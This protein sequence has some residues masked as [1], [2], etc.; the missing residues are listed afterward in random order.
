M[1]LEKND[2]LDITI[3]MPCL[4][5]EKTIGACIE[6]AQLF[7]QRCERTGEV[8]VV[9]NGSSDRSAEIAR[10]RHAR[11]I[12]EPRRGYGSAL[13]R[14]LAMAEGR[15]ILLGDCDQTYDF[16][17]MGDMLMALEQ[18]ADL[19]IG[20]R[21]VAADVKTVMPFSHY[22]GVKL[23][24]W[25]G[26]RRYHTNVPDYHCGLRGLKKDAYEKLTLTCSGMEFAT[27]MIAEAAHEK[28][29]IEVVSVRLKHCPAPRVSHLRTIPDGMRHLGYMLKRR[30]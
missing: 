11:V 30:S 12:C 8:L 9:D 6:D 18:G 2:S 24:S 19:V 14:G 21:F 3:L 25:I 26:N 13:R 23:L 10:N 27:E 22:W 28:L 7:L 29:R 1:T 17:A 15:I 4:N 16:L 20:N 5:E